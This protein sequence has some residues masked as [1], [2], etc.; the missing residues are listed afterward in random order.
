MYITSHE[1]LNI[2]TMQILLHKNM[3]Y[4][5]FKVTIHQIDMTI[6]HSVQTSHFPKENL[7]PLFVVRLPFLGLREA[8]SLFVGNMVILTW[9]ANLHLSRTKTI[10]NKKNIVKV[11]GGGGMV[12]QTF[13]P[14]HLW[15]LK[16]KISP[17]NPCPAWSL[18]LPPSLGLGLSSKPP[19]L[20]L[21]LR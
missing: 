5:N 6:F 12:K 2:Y 8:P 21:R 7:H 17:W 15:T 18:V 10:L 3:P 20:L 16:N 13:A 19:S 14:F 1:T 4:S 9:T 11:R